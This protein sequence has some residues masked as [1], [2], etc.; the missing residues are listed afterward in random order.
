MQSEEKISVLHGV[1]Q[2]RRGE[3]GEKQK[4]KNS[5]NLRECSVN[6][7]VIHSTCYT[8]LPRGGPENTEKNKI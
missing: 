3:H 2:R 8:E 6:L 1:T 5:V 4:I 7:R